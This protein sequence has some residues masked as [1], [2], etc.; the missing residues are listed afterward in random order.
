MSGDERRT[1]LAEDS[2]GL[3]VGI[4]QK[5]H[6]KGPGDGT[7][8][9]CAGTKQQAGDHSTGYVSMFCLLEADVKSE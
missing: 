6:A 5:P 7:R 4:S 1:I 3:H 9:L 2:S 8:T